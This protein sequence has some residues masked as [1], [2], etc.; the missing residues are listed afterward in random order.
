MPFGSRRQAVRV[1]ENS[2]YR[3]L[4]AV[5][6]V[7][8]FSSADAIEDRISIVSA[9]FSSSEADAEAERLNVVAQSKNCHYVVMITRLK[10]QDDL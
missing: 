6:R 10:E 9:F 7:D 4:H 2:R 5:V 3:H 1:Q 8:D